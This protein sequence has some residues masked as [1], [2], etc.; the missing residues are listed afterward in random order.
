VCSKPVRVFDVMLPL[1]EVFH[2]R[3]SSQSGL[4]SAKAPS[5]HPS[6]YAIRDLTESLGAKIM[7]AWEA[8]LSHLLAT[9]CSRNVATFTPK[10][11]P[12]SLPAK[13]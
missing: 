5:Q 10:S 13:R 6:S 7:A 8:A 1:F 3:M 11:A 4:T 2:F 9:N 12:C